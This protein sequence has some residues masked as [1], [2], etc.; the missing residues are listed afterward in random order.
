MN[1]ETLEKQYRALQIIWVAMLLSLGAYVAVG[2]LAGD[3][4]RQGISDSMP[5]DTI[6]TIL[7]GVSVVEL[8]GIHYVR[9]TM[10][11]LS[12][13]TAQQAVAQRYSVTSIISYAVS[14]S[15]GI[16]GLV[17]YFLGDDIQSLYVLMGISALA[18]VYY[19]PKY[20]VLKDLVRKAA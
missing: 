14:E 12:R 17:L 16:Y 19:R 18:M 1:G 2:Q 13:G 3:S 20:E 15:I 10:L 5:L 4:I 6:R 9:K 11:R 7:F 8:I